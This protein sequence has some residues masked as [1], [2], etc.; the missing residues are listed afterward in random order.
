MWKM[1]FYRTLEV[2]SNPHY[3]ELAG[4]HGDQKLKHVHDTHDEAMFG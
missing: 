4:T 3:S 1:I 2:A